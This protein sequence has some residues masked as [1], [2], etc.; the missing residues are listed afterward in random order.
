KADGKAELNDGLP[1]L[2]WWMLPAPD[3]RNRWRKGEA[4]TRIVKGVVAGVKH[5]L[6]SGV[7]IDGRPVSASNIAVLVR[8]NREGVSI[9]DALREAGIPAVVSKSG[10]IWRS[11]EMRSE[12]HTSE[13]QSR[14]N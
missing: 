2:V 4:R 14:E 6:R 9:Q 12:E 11:S 1:P 8:E 5:L 10:D 3:E 13:L 7:T